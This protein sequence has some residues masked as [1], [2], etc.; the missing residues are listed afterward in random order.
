MQDIDINID[1]IVLHGFARNDYE[2]IKTAIEAELERLIREKGIP[3]ILSSPLRYRQIEGGTFKMN[4]GTGMVKVG[5]E[6]AGTVYN[7]LKN[8]KAQKNI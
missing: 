7:G 4:R 1:E 3:S 5:N 8:L 2:G 6:I